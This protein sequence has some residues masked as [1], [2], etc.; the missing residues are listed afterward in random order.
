I[1][2]SL[3]GSGY[4][5]RSL[6]GGR[7]VFSL[8]VARWPRSTVRGQLSCCAEH[9]HELSASTLAEPLAMRV[10]GVGV[11]LTGSP[12]L[13]VEHAADLLLRLFLGFQ[14][15][16]H[17]APL[18]TPPSVLHCCCPP[19]LPRRLNASLAVTL[20]C[21]R[22]RLLSRI[23]KHSVDPFSR[24]QGRRRPPDVAFGA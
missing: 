11:L 13:S 2:S 19:A 4:R 3:S 23:S 10:V 5:R 18:L 1:G 8:S 24:R 17:R 6:P 14:L 12:H 7:R 9:P 15:R 16:N 21:A 22:D 20:Q